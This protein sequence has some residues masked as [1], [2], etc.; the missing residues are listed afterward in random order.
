MTYL[1][2]LALLPL[3]IILSM[4]ADWVVKATSFFAKKFKIQSFLI[5]FLLLGVATTI[6]E[7]F[8]AFQSIQDGVPQL[9]IGNLLGGSI[10]LLSFVMG[11]SAL[12][13]G[14]IILNHGM[15]LLDIGMSSLVVA[16]PALALWDGKLTRI[17]GFVLV[18][19]YLLHVIL[20]SKEQHVV[21]HIEH[22]AKHVRHAGHGALMLGGGL[23]LLG[24]TSRSIVF[25]AE[26]LSHQ[27]SLSPFV[28]GLFI[29]T[30][31]TNLPEIT[32]VVQAIL[33]KKRDIAFG[34]V[35]G[36][37]VINTPLLGIVCIAA[38]FS[39]PDHLRMRTTLILLAAVSAFF[40]WAASTKK[41]VNRKEG[42]VLLLAYGVFIFIEAMNI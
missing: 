23:L 11:V 13:L 22:H 32:L 37:A 36:S 34:D 7:M 24:V 2:L 31:G 21:D 33:S 39:V 25:I 6:P 30:L 35:L 12:F 40:W 18:G 41:D 20:I 17:E 29:V 8:V 15:T 28:I 4:S 42:V 5:G 9:S 19:V 16:A 3:G 1:Y 27:W 14:R 38:P 26:Y 10:L